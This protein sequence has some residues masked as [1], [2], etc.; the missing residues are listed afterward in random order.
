MAGA[1]AL[2]SCG[3]APSAAAP[4]EPLPVE[5]VRVGA[6]GASD[7][8]VRGV[9]SIAWQ[10]ESDLSFRVP[11]I[12]TALSVDIG[13]KV[14]VG[15]PVA[16]LDATDAAARLRQANA[17]VERAE[18]VVTRQAALAETGAVARAQYQDA[19]TILA[20]A[21]AARDAA[22]FDSRSTRL[23]SPVSGVVL[24]RS[25]QA[26]EVV[27]PGQAIIRVAD[28]ASPLLIRVP[29]P[30]REAARIRPGAEAR[31]TIDALPGAPL[32]GRVRRIGRQ[33]DARTGTVMVEIALARRAGLESGMIGT[34]EIAIS[35]TGAEA[36][37]P[38]P[39]EALIE[40]RDGH[41]TVFLLDPKTSQA[42]KRTVRFAGFSGEDALVAGLPA[43]A[44][45]ITSGAGYALDGQSVRVAASGA[46]QQ[47]AIR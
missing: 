2:A 18:R 12:M 39:A 1:G 37:V 33:A 17:D 22:S 32:A 7:A 38:I 19:Q 4:A 6:A 45:L 11:G 15:Q 24:A 44:A 14:R 41:G 20:Q 43:G 35:S 13:D 23:V 40:A 29:L 5:I 26:G 47:A 30:D 34:A 3:Q 46:G 9:G 36:L 16:M 27:S 28:E 25:A 42:R 31:V 21:R 10:R 8:V